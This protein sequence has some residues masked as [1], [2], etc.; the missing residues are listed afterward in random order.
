MRYSG[1]LIKKKH[2]VLFL[3][4]FSIIFLSGCRL[5]GI[6]Y[7]VLDEEHPFWEQVGIAAM[8]ATK[9]AAMLPTEDFEEGLKP[10]SAQ[11]FAWQSGERCINAPGNDPCPLE[12]CVVAKDQFSVV[13]EQSVEL[14]GKSNPDNYSCAADIRFSNNSGSNVLFF[15]LI[16]S[17]EDQ[18]FNVGTRNIAVDELFEENRFTYFD[19]H[20]GITKYRYVSALATI[21]DNPHCSW[22]KIDD[23]KLWE[24]SLE[25]MDPCRQ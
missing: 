17:N 20:E 10:N 5:L 18:L 12:A 4:S 11:E 15:Y 13:I 19:R 6:A 21:L 2:I 24:N 16:E 8:E 1:M 3:L 7:S 22:I 23:T 14:I 25:L 9:D